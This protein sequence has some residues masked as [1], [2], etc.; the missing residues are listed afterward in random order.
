MKNLILTLILISLCQVVNA[1]SND[2][3]TTDFSKSSI[4][5]TDI[6]SGGPPKDGIPAIFEPKFLPQEQVNDIKLGEPT[7]SLTLGGEAHA[8]PIRILIWH[9]VVNDVVGGVPVVVTYCP[10]TN[11]ARV[12][13][14]GDLEFGVTG[15]LYNS[16]MVMYDKKT[17]SWWQQYTGTSIVG[18]QTGQQLEVLASGVESLYLFKTWHPNGKIL[19]PNDPLAR[20]YGINPYPGYDTYF[21]IL[22]K[23]EYHGKLPKMDYLIAVGNDAWPLD[24]LRKKKM[25]EYNGITLSWQPY[26]NDALD[27]AEI[28]LGRDVGTVIVHRKTDGGIED[29]PYITPFAFAFDAFQ[30]DGVVHSE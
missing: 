16:N 5:I 17:Q 28:A 25:V 24:L 8:Y 4:N 12:F 7:I 6:I 1:A 22:Y 29:L 20:K 27:S 10:L 26:Q 13:K 9:Q 21:P 2:W 11:V 14:R 3:P 23:G 19:V 15:K 30:K 18:K